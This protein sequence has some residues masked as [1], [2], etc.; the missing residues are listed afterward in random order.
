M[1]VRID[2]TDVMLIPAVERVFNSLGITDEH[3]IVCTIAGQSEIASHTSLEVI[4]DTVMLGDIPVYY[5]QEYFVMVL[6]QHGAFL[7]PPGN[8][9]VYKVIADT[10]LDG[11]CLNSGEEIV[12]SDNRL[13]TSTGEV[14]VTRSFEK[15]LK[16]TAREYREHFVKVQDQS[17]S[18]IIGVLAESEECAIRVIPGSTLADETEYGI[19][20]ERNYVG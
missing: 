17:I 13:V 4:V 5:M 20:E 8:M 3:S 12:L 18:R 7:P 15:K 19:K 16:L 14:M 1:R 2:L 10:I 9:R 6:R 11:I